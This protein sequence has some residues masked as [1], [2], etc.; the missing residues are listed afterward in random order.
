MGASMNRG[1]EEVADVPAEPCIVPP[2]LDGVCAQAA[3]GESGRGRERTAD[4]GPADLREAL[5]ALGQTL[6]RVRKFT[7]HSQEKL[8]N[9][10][11]VTQSAL[12]RLESGR[13]VGLVILL[14]LGRVL[15]RMVSA[16]E[17][18]VL[19]EETRRVLAA[20]QV[21]S[22][23]APGPRS[24]TRTPDL[25]ELIDLFHRAPRMVRDATLAVL[26]TLGRESAGDPPL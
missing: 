10:A 16:G 12:S 9:L 21:L 25:A 26:R 22:S 4:H 8:A 14:R 1:F 11:G 7:G 18:A 5:R 2:P 17:D 3:T 6:L 24:V 20:L 19:S 13:P 15:P 23:V